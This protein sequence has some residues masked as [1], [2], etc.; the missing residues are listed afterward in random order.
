[1]AN[2]GINELRLV[3]PRDDWPNKKAFAT[4]SGAHWIL[5]GAAGA[6]DDCARRSP[7]MHFV[8]AT[9]ARPREMIKEVVTPAQG[10]RIGSDSHL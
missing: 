5:E 2:F 10:I 4:S 6:R 1:M 9:T 7:D 8:Y 3:D